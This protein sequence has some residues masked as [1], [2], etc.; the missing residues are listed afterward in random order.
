MPPRVDVQGHVQLL[1]KRIQV[2][3][4]LINA[5][6]Y[7]QGYKGLLKGIWDRELTKLIVR[8]WLNLCRNDRQIFIV[9]DQYYWNSIKK[10]IL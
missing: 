9:G 1:L 8:S 3:R 10:H 4:S 2:Y 7:A 5:D 6:N